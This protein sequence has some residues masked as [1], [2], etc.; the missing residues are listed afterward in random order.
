MTTDD[1]AVSRLLG[2]SSRRTFLKRGT[3]AATAL[4]LGGTAT[5][6]AQDG[7][8]TYFGLIPQGQ[9]RGGARFQIVSEAIGYAPV[10][11][12]AQGQEYATRAIKYTGAPGNMMLF[13]PQNADLQQGQVYQFQP[14][15]TPAFGQ[16]DG[17]GPGFEQGALDEDLTY[18]NPLELGL[19]QVQFSPVQGGSQQGGNQT[20]G[21][22]T[23][24]NQTDG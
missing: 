11:R 23:A 5:A 20:A 24:G 19:L 16:Q 18:E 15:Y 21:N 3:F 14:R 9:F 2:E 22:Q 10:Q 17:V 8:Q 1:T 4:G 6:A 7:D 13:V 12:D